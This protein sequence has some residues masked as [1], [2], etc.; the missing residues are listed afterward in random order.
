MQQTVTGS[1]LLTMGIAQEHGFLQMYVLTNKR[2]GVYDVSFSMK[3]MFIEPMKIC[4]GVAQSGR[5]L[6]ATDSAKAS[7]GRE[8]SQVQILPPPSNPI[9]TAQKPL[10]ERLNPQEPL[11]VNP[12]VPT[13]QIECSGCGAMIPEG[14]PCFICDKMNNALRGA[15]QIRREYALMKASESKTLSK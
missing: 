12:S 11:P 3:K 5:A 7:N 8:Q 4:G 15:R 1:T 2:N 9:T 13:P 14:E 6:V 10:I